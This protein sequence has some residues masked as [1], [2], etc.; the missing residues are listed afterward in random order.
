MMTVN[1]YTIDI[2]ATLEDFLTGSISGLESGS[3]EENINGDGKLSLSWRSMDGGGLPQGTQVTVTRPGDEVGLGFY[4][5]DNYAPSANGDGTYTWSPTFISEDSKL[6]GI[7]IYR[8][9]DL[10][11]GGWIGGQGSTRTVRIYTWPYMGNAATLVSY[12]NQFMPGGSGIVLGSEYDNRGISVSF[13]Q[14]NIVSACQKIADALGTNSTIEGGSICIGTH[15][16]VATG[17]RYNRFIVMGGTRNMGKLRMSESDTYAAVTLRLQLDE[18]KYPNSVMPAESSSETGVGKMTKFL[19]FDD[20][21]PKMELTVGGVRIRTCYLYDEEGRQMVDGNNNPLTYNKYYIT[22][23]LG[24]NPYNFDKSTVIQGRTLGIVFQSGLL[25]GRE[26]DLAYYDDEGGTQTIPVEKE[27]DDVSQA[28]FQPLNGEYRICLVA[29]GDTLLPN[30]SL[31]PA[32]GDK[33]TLVGVA[34][35]MK[36][37][38]EAQERLEKAAQYY[39]GLYS[40]DAPT[41]VSFNSEKQVPDFLTEIPAA[42]S[43][44]TRYNSPRRSS[45]NGL[46]DDHGSYI[47]TSVTTDIMSG[48]QQIHYGTFEPKGLLSGVANLLETAS[49]R[50]GGAYVGSD[51]DEF[52]R[53]TGAM[54]LDQFKTLYEI[55]G[56]LGMKTV[57]NRFSNVDEAMEA[58]RSSFNDV[59][60]QSDRKFDIWFLENAPYPQKDDA[61][62]ANFPASDWDTDDEKE[63]HV[64]DIAYDVS[65]PSD[66]DGGRTWRWVSEEDGNGNII[67]YW[68]RITDGDTL[69]ALEMLSD[70]AADNVLTPAEK[71]VARRD[72]SANVAEFAALIQRA[73]TAEVD[74]TAYSE[75]YYALR[76]YL[77]SPTV[78]VETDQY[79]LQALG[80]IRNGDVT[81]AYTLLI[82]NNITTGTESLAAYI[83]DG[84]DDD[85]AAAVTALEAD[86]HSQQK[87]DA[88][89]INSSGNTVINGQ[90]WK[91]LWDGYYSERTALLSALSGKALGELDDMAA[92]NVLTDIEKLAIIR[93]YE[94]IKEETRELLQQASAAGLDDDSGSTQEAYREAYS[95]LYSYLDDKTS[96]YT[97]TDDLTQHNNPAM[98]YNGETTAIN[99]STFTSL[100]S[101]YYNAAA[102]LRAA[103]RSAGQRVFVGATAPNPPYKVGDLWVKTSDDKYKL[104]I[105]I[106]ASTKGQPNDAHWTEHEVYK[107]AR[108]LLASLADYVFAHYESSMPVTVTLGATCSITGNVQ[109]VENT[110]AL[111]YHFLGACTF[112]ISKANSLPGSGS[113]YDLC[114]IP[115]SFQIPGSQEVLTGG[116]KISMWN[117]SGWE[118]L[119]E[120]TSALIQNLGN[121]INAVVFGSSAAATEAAGLSIGQRFAKMFA[122]AQ[123]YDPQNP[124]ADQNGFVTL[125]QALFGLSIQQDDNGRYYSSAKLSADKI[126][127]QGK[128][129]DLSAGQ[130]NFAGQTVSMTANDTLTFSGGSI[131]F[132]A[133]T[134]IDFNAAEINLNADKVNWKKD[135]SQD[136][137][138]GDVIPGAN[139]SDPNY[140]PETDSK[141]YVD[142]YGNVTMN[143]LKANNA[144][145]KGKLVTA[146][147][148]IELTSTQQSGYVWS[149]LANPTDSIG[150]GYN[151]A[152][153]IGIR[154]Y[155]NNNYAA[156]LSMRGYGNV[157]GSI[158]I[159]AGKEDSTNPSAVSIIRM[160]PNSTTD[161]VVLD[162]VDGSVESDKVKVNKNLLLNTNKI[163]STS[164]NI[165]IT[166]AE[167]QMII[168]TS[169]GDQT[170]TLASTPPN[171][172]IIIIKKT[173]NS[174]YVEVKNASN[175]VI[176]RFGEGSIICVYDSGWQ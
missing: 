57:N 114:C 144:E 99:G 124:L 115:V 108:S 129:I 58:L 39:V 66:S 145:L 136:G 87:G 170:V 130:I 138:S 159:H 142:E 140:D 71:L 34:L 175:N 36:Y 82:S 149:G 90:T 137:F 65:R 51:D 120:S 106:T 117:G 151:D 113:L 74:A 43:P 101:G 164:Q 141:F 60:Q 171:G 91:A 15:S 94:R 85:L 8:N 102:S 146:S 123:V 154:D 24:A 18:T 9:V 139:S 72:W 152:V 26:F 23:S 133:T 77:H 155:G 131:V 21:Y 166:N 86:L 118:F 69:A 49:V 44:G 79:L 111:L 147:G 172:T 92:D 14:D 10:Q 161:R 126:E 81:D 29:D 32:V 93:E 143:N 163:L 169:N 38:T 61:T 30:A 162:G 37:Y 64:Q 119:Q 76:A 46:G 75:A 134:S 63:I 25:A 95:L 55:Y 62:A 50:G 48:T 35:D 11:V 27:E 70:M 173:T 31:A 41:E 28:G 16:A 68:E 20:I 45:G 17:E 110:L 42:P 96:G 67:Y 54:S 104:M 156:R 153:A 84:D 83:S 1:G 112:A 98:L 158:T 121:K 47:V 40:S 103:I 80:M 19:I 122:T 168:C 5:Q 97:F 73:A 52:I 7:V 176:G 132:D 53:H 165:N 157:S 89:I 116:C 150:I 78:Y 100:W 128:T 105:C 12:L 109:G 148:K 13:D 167:I 125:T 33:V 4:L 6:K 107:D 135:N 3:F 2:D 174:G 22:L 160:G 127:F 59:Q 88:A 56:H